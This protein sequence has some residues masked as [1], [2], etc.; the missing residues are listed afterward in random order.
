MMGDSLSLPPFSLPIP[1]SDTLVKL[2]SPRLSV[3]RCLLPFRS[4]MSKASLGLHWLLGDI[5]VTA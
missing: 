1:S 5:H 3:A 4:Q 2:E